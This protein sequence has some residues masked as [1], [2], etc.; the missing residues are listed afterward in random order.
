MKRGIDPSQRGVGTSRHTPRTV[1]LPCA[2]RGA[3]HRIVQ[4]AHRHRRVALGLLLLVS[5]DGQRGAAFLVPERG[6]FLVEC[7]ELAAASR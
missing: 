6:E 7:H 1:G 4:A 5:P 3:T 2:V